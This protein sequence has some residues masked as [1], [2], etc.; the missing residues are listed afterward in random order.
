MAL[1]AAPHELWPKPA[2]LVAFL[3]GVTLLGGS[4][5]FYVK[6]ISE[7]RKVVPTAIAAEFR[8][9]IFYDADG[10]LS[11]FMAVYQSTHGTTASPLYFLFYLQLTNRRDTPRKINAYSVAI[12][13]HE[14]GPWKP[15]RSV[16]LI[17]TKPFYIGT[18]AGDAPE[19]FRHSIHYGRGTYRLGT[20]PDGELLKKSVQL[21]FQSIF[22][23]KVQDQIAPHGTLEG[24]IAF[25]RSDDFFE[26]KEQIFY[27]IT[28]RDSAGNSDSVV[29][30][31]PRPPEGETDTGMASMTPIGPTV[32]LSRAF[33]KFYGE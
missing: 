11:P 33:L 25:G 15:L 16:S 27:K 5:Y 3:L 18:N 14:S 30:R 23:L 26:I 21:N 2:I 24:W 22:D 17:N 20:K 4:A 29:I 12:S 6:D 10:L 9:A 19:G 7:S 32:D 8:T 28:I 13:G 31:P 1:G